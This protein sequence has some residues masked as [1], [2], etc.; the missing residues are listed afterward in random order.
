MCVSARQM[1]NVPSVTMNGGRLRPT[2][3]PP[4]TKPTIMQ[5][6]MPSRIESTGGTPESTAS[7]VITIEPEGHRGAAGQV[8]AG[9]EDDQRLADGQRADHHHLLDDQREVRRVAGT[10]PTA[11]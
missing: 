11:S 9:G 8:D 3:R 6:A 4:L 2:T 1:L 5:V 7:L 10:G